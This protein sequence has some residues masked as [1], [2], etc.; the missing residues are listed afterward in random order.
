MNSENHVKATWGRVFGAAPVGGAVGFVV[1]LVVVAVDPVPGVPVDPVPGVPEDVV[2]VDVVL[3]LL[4]VLVVVVVL[5]LRVAV[6]V[7]VVLELPV[8]VPVAVVVVLVEAV[9][10][11]VVDGSGISLHGSW[12]GPREGVAL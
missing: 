11:V 3:E 4:V 10:V 12:L 1:E 7:V 9:V 6:F 8:A 2:D 5:E